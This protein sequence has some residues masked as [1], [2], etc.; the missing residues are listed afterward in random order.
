MGGARF[1][2]KLAAAVARNDS[3]LCVGLDPDPAQMPEPVRERPDW[4]TRFA[5]GIVEA[6]ADLVCC[7]KPNLAFYEA[8]GEAGLAGLRATLRAMPADVPV[9]LD[10]KRG[11][12][13]VSA[14]AYAAALFDDLGADAVTVSPYLGFDTL[15]PF[16]AY[17]DRGVFVL[18]KTS[19]PGAAEFQDQLVAMNGSF[20]PLYESVAA[21]AVRANQHG[22]VGLVVGATHPE[23]F[24]NVRAVAPD[25]PLLVPGV[26]AQGGDLAMAVDEGQDRRGGGL[27][28]ASSRA[29]LYASRGADWQAEARDAAW[30]L[31][32][33]INARRQGRAD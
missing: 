7:Y 31:R 18:C 5:A 27:L 28:V 24:R 22:N 9:L 30:E 15:E 4:L 23:A 33:A 10:A 21:A 25:L 26:G 16:L 14:R 13:G 19:N 6:T 2:D 12:I 32:G 1:A 3:L 29:I 8:L 17:G 11:D 20:R